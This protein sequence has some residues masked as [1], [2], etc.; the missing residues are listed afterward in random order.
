MAELALGA[1]T[2]LL[3]VIRNEWRLL[4]RVGGDVQF[5]R[6]EMESMNSFLMHLARTAP[7]SSEHDEQVR[8]WMNQ[9]RLLAQDCNNCID[10][11]LYRGN[12]DIHL[13]RDRLR[14]YLRW[15][16]WFLQKML[17]QHRAAL[18]LSEL[19]ER[20]RDVGK[21]RLRYGVEIP[22]KAAVPPGTGGSAAAE[23]S[24]EAAFVH[25]DGE[26]D[27]H[28][29]DQVAGA[30][31]TDGSGRIRRA[32]FGLYVL[33]DYF[34]D[35][36]AVWIE[37]VRHQ[38][39]ESKWQHD[40]RCVAFVVPD[41]ENSG[42]IARQASAVAEKHVKNTILVDIPL[43]HYWRMLGPK[44]ILYYILREIELRQQQ[45]QQGQGIDW[46]QIRGEKRAVISKI[47]K[48]IEP[49]NVI[50][51]VEEIMTYIENAKENKQLKLYLEAYIEKAKEDKQL[52]VLDGPKKKEAQEKITKETSLGVLLVLLLLMKSMPALAQHYDDIIKQTSEMLKKHM[53][54]VN[55]GRDKG[56]RSID[57]REQKQSTKVLDN[58]TRESPKVL[59]RLSISGNI[60]Q[61]QLSTLLLTDKNTTLIKV[62]L[63]NA[64]LDPTI[65][66][67]LSNLPKLQCLKLRHNTY[68]DNKLT[69]KKGE[70]KKL[71]YFL[72][73]GSNWIEISFE[74]GTAAPELEKIVLSFDNIEYIAGVDHLKKL[75]ELELNKYNKS[76]NNS[77]GSTDTAATN[78]DPSALAATTAA[79]PSPLPLNTT[80]VV[81]STP[82]GTHPAPSSP[83]GGA[84]NPS[85]LPPNTTTV[86]PSTPIGPNPAPSPSTGGAANPSPHTSTIDAAN[87]SPLP[88][89][90]TI[91]IPSTPT[92]P[93][94]APSASTGGAANPSPHTS[95][96]DTAN[97]SP[98]P[99]NTTT[100]IPS[101]PT[102]P[103]P[104]PSSST[105]S[106]AN[107][108]PLPR[109]TTTV[110]PSTT[111]PAPS[112]PTGVAAN[113][114]AHITT[115]DTANP[116]LSGPTTSSNNVLL[117]KL[118]S[119]AKQISKVTLRGT[120]L[121][122]DGMR[123]LAR[124]ENI[125]CLVLLQGSYNQNRLDLNKDEYAKLNLLIVKCP[126]ITEIKFERGS[127][128]KLEKIVWTFDQGSSL[129]GI[130]HLPR[131][132]ELE[133][134]GDSLPDQVKEGIDKHKHKDM[135]HCTHY[136]QE[137]Q[138]QT[139]RS[140]GKEDSVPSCL[141]IWKDKGWRRRN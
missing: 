115:A 118:L 10:L 94:P 92:G 30:T 29:H 83:T 78:Q 79:N 1:V 111:H 108:S 46:R 113:P 68:S 57:S 66:E 98:L 134:T 76:S 71:R 97:P 12:P 141:Y 22:K 128:P 25:L 123:T 16:P 69:F 2:S 36:L 124:M 84:A 127:A 65:L 24:A 5:I 82:T 64:S 120:M 90:T 55:E 63:S 73:E 42:A 62:T 77:G 49:L 122:E 89:N 4:G 139:G 34:N 43:L 140:T 11:Y 86:A 18:E 9:V 54:Q 52:E 130:E 75:E 61:G 27:E 45:Q 53:E 13:G 138:D 85:P 50:R 80:T 48:D 35:Q 91:V 20:A 41:T 14:R 6:E 17:A 117:P 105:G 74:E 107:P 26:E 44:N 96:I 133:F 3:G 88:P 101:T 102:G 19:K 95:T 28:E 104:A 72:V 132:K 99:P 67:A 110:V 38:W 7:P 116:S 125:R 81:P 33:E 114:T 51:K 31:A 60:L 131:L 37:Q 119:D 121:A 109:N 32:L 8:T 137:R 136:K 126:E 100:V 23:G 47:K 129:S 87:P 103:N 15:F 58:Q 56:A 135:I 21:R 106:A 59:E 112:P 70:F 40:T 93:N 39:R